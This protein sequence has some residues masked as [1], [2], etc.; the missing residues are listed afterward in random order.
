MEIELS[1]YAMRLGRHIAHVSEKGLTDPIEWKVVAERFTHDD[2]SHMV[3]AAFELKAVG[4]LRVS[5][6]M[7]AVDSISSIRPEYDLYWIFDQEVFNYDTA[8]DIVTLIDL[9][10]EDENRGAAATLHACLDWTHRRLNPAFARIV[11]EIPEGRV[12]ST[13]QPDYV[14]TGILMTP[15]DRV[16][17]RALR[18][19]LTYDSTTDMP[20]DTNQQPA[21]NTPRHNDIPSKKIAIKVP[22][23]E[24]PIGVPRWTLPPILVLVLV[25]MVAWNWQE[26][27]EKANQ[28]G[29]G[30]EP[31]LLTWTIDAGA[32]SAAQ[33]RIPPIST[34]D[35]K[36]EIYVRYEGIHERP[37]NPWHQLTVTVNGE[38]T[39]EPEQVGSKPDDKNVNDFRIVHDLLRNATLDIK[40]E[41]KNYGTKNES[42][43][44]E[45]KELN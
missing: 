42:L 19:S 24:V 23:V 25:G 17:L 20:T 4:F 38:I 12:R 18:K 29:M 31:V 5:Q 11:D 9:I 10:L 45:A 44:I 43:M 37:G 32:S 16:A 33:L 7:G 30:S 13:L 26:V 1:E 3:E 41:V 22:Y 34:R 27:V 14:T 15:E 39:N 21:A 6:A 36:I 40:A 8:A 35:R 2:R 28:L